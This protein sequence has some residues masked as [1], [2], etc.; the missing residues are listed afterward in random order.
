[1]ATRPLAALGAALAAVWLTAA[2]ADGE[3]AYPQGFR[4]WAHVRTGTIG[5]ANPAFAHFGGMHSIYA[6]KPALAG[7]RTG[8]FQDGSVL[9]F[10]VL[11]MT[12]DK[13]IGVA[14]DRRLIDVM[15]KDSK[16]FKATGGWGYGE[17]KGSSH[18]ERTL[19]QAQAAS[20]C[21][22]CHQ[23]RTKTDSVF[24]AIQGGEA[25]PGG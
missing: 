23:T 2:A 15:E 6:N 18:S 22:A 1:M 4:A 14:G 12:T 3:V 20:N 7:Y 17:F 16:R 5:P 11:A 19:L 13:D 9:V 10:D 8:R 25:M 21:H 24:G